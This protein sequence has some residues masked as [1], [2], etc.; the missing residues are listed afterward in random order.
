[1]IKTACHRLNLKPFYAHGFKF[2]CRKTN[3]Q[4][5]TKLSVFLITI[6]YR[7]KIH[8]MALLDLTF[9]AIS[10][11]LEITV[12]NFSSN[13]YCYGIIGSFDEIR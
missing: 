5:Q 1:M 9:M 6:Q 3:G 11:A 10:P 7:Q 8:D 13:K 2:L 4:H 12:F